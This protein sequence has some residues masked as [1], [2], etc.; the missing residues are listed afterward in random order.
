VSMARVGAQ[1]R[2]NLKPCV[3]VQLYLN[4]VSMSFGE[5]ADNTFE[6]QY[7]LATPLWPASLNAAREEQGLLKCQG[8]RALPAGS[9]AYTWPNVRLPLLVSAY[10]FLLHSITSVSRPYRV[11]IALPVSYKRPGLMFVGSFT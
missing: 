10:P 9:P 1:P 11:C 6:V 2:T 5:S 8:S 4:A 3:C 7:P